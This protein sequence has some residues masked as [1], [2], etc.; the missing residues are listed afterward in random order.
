[1][2]ETASE[3]IGAGFESLVQLLG[4]SHDLFEGH[5]GRCVEK[6]GEIFDACYLHE[7]AFSATEECSDEVE[8]ELGLATPH[9]EMV[10]HLEPV[11]PIQHFGHEC[12]Q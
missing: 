11:F 1:M 6:D 4:Q 7:L 8:K 10:D 3:D 5:G 12:C 9:E 2:A